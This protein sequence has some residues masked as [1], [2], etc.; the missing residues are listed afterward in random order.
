MRL[1]V[2]YRPFNSGGKGGQHSNKTLN[3]IEASVVLPDGRKIKAQSTVYKCQHRNKKE[4]QKE[5]VRRVRQALAVPR[6]RPDTSER[7]R[8]YHA[9]R[10]EVLDHASGVKRRYDDVLSGDAFADLVDARR[11]ALEAERLLGESGNVP[12]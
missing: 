8:T 6:V 2:S 9:C 7:V 5:L 3:A 12:Q 11:E 10:N 1:Q 4:A